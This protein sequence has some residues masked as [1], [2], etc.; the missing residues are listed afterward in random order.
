[1]KRGV[2]LFLRALGLRCP[3][4][5]GGPLFA[6]WFRLTPACPKCGL[7]LEREGGYFTGSITINLVVTEIVW[8]LSFVLML[9]ATWP[10]PPVALL[11]WGSI[12]LMI[13]F[14]IAFFRHS[15]TLWLAFDLLFRPI[16]SVEGKG[17]DAGR[18]KGEG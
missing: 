5:G 18:P 9:M 3:Q 6:S 15:K 10:T 16:E 17:R 2:I 13:L 4:C 1:V 12:L 14:P 11:Q 7:R 8:A